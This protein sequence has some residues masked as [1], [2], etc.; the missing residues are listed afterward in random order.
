MKLYLIVAKA[1]GKKVPLFKH[2][3]SIDDE[4]LGKIKEK[5]HVEPF[6]FPS[7]KLVSKSAAK[8]K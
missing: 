6:K 2:L 7:A 3:V 8:P 5:Y 1:F 4:H